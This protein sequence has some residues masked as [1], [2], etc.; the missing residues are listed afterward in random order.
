MSENCFPKSLLKERASQDIVSTLPKQLTQPEE[1]ASREELSA[2]AATAS[3]SFTPATT[4]ENVAPILATPPLLLNAAPQCSV[5]PSPDNTSPSRVNL[6]GCFC[7]NVSSL[8]EFNS[9][10]QPYYCHVFDRGNFFTPD[11]SASAALRRHIE[12]NGGDNGV[13]VAWDKKDQ[14]RD[15][16]IVKHYS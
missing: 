2:S 13:D 8:P 10:T 9:G 11:P 5:S 14:G 16:P 1:A 12:N 3:S 15:S 6:L 7:L 4:S